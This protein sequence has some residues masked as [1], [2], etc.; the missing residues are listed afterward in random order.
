MGT[1]TPHGDSSIYDALVR[2]AQRW[3]M[4]M[5]LV[6]SNRRFRF[7]GNDQAAAMRYAECKMIPLSMEMVRDI[8]EETVN[9]Q[10]NYDGRN[11]EPTVLPARFRTCWSTASRGDRG[12]RV[13]TNIPP[14]NL[15]EVAAGAQWYLEHPEACASWTR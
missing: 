9:Y 4:R 3:S 10:D 7:P 1:Y 11:Q 15:R 8:D 2:L 5:P 12:G 14:H 6:D 13:A